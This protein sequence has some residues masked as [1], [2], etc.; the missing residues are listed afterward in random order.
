M[1]MPS[2]D[3]NSMEVNIDDGSIFFLDRASRCIYLYSNDTNAVT[4]IRCG[5]SQS[6][7]STIAYDWLG[8]NI[9]W[10]DGFFNWIA[11]QPVNTNDT[12]IYRVLIQNNM[13]KPRAISVDPVTGLMFWFDLSPWG[14]RIERASLDGTD[15]RLVITQSLLSVHD[16]V[17]DCLTSRL[18][19]T[20]AKRFTIE[21][22]NYDGSDRQI[23]YKRSDN[24]FRSISIDMNYVCATTFDGQSWR[25]IHKTTG[26][27]QVTRVNEFSASEN[28]RLISIYKQDTKPSLTGIPYVKS[29]YSM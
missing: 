21:S 7:Y 4:S 14:Y 23:V 11:V 25:C 10:T 5:I 18:Y 13:E 8:R 26:N 22:S 9:Y 19:W 3:I 24:Y 17:A 1:G 20:D 28:P 29:Q 2:A 16:I 15:R 12:S 6:I 27:V